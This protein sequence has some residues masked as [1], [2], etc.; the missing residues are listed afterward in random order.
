MTAADRFSVLC[1]C[2]GN[3]C[4]SPAAERLLA[5]ALGPEVAVSSAGTL[6]LVGRPM[7]PPMDAL[8]ATAGADPTGFAAQRLTERLLQP[9]DLVL[10]LTRAHRGDVVGLW[11]KA[12][13]RTFTLKEFARLLQELDPGLLPAGGVAERLRAAVPLVAAR[14]RQV[15]DERLDDVLDPYRQPA[16]VYEEAF[17]DVRRAVADVVA[18]VRPR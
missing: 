1:V 18:V 3:V 14:R 6:A 8:V 16:E 13:R 15:P 9:V 17:A 5:A 12:V 10:A 7:S 2:T 11:P 4:R